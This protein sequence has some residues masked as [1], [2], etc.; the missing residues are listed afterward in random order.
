[1]PPRTP[2]RRP[3][4]L[5]RLLALLALVLGLAA[6]AGAASAAPEAA[7]PFKVIA[8]Y[9][10]TWDAAHVDFVKE[11]NQWFPQAGADNGFTYRA[12]TDWNLLA[13]GGV[14]E[15]QVVLFLDDAPQTAAQR[16]GF[17][18]YV[19]GGGG[20][21]GFH[22]SAFTTN[23]GSWPWYYNSFLGSG[24]FRSNTWGPTTA[25]LRTE[26]RSHP[27]PPVCPAPSPR[28]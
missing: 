24:D 12:T 6:P 21:M 5:A 15:Y 22:V 14:D 7:A 27:R 19:R 17:E 23:A 25:V 11:A 9:N 3:H 16:S 20:W 8:F 1:M 18:R 28:P 13:N 2:P 10:G 4:F 26:D